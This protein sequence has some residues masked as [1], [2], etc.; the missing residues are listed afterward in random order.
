MGQVM[1]RTCGVDSGASCSPSW[2]DPAPT[3]AV[4]ALSPAV[5]GVTR[6]PAAAGAAPTRGLSGSAASLR[7]NLAPSVEV[8]GKGH[9]RAPTQLLEPGL[10][11]T[12]LPGQTSADRRSR[13]MGRMWGELRLAAEPAASYQADDSQVNESAGSGACASDATGTAAEGI[14]AAQIDAA[15][16]DL[17]AVLDRLGAASLGGLDAKHL[18]VL[19]ERIQ[20]ELGR[21]TALRASVTSRW[22][23]QARAAAGRGREQQVER[24]T[25][26]LLRDRLNLPPGEAKRTV[27]AGQQADAPGPVGDGFRDGRL[28]EAHLA[29]IADVGRGLTPDVRKRLEAELSAAAQELDPVALGRLAR[30]RLI[31]LEPENERRTEQRRHMRRRLSMTTTEDGGVRVSGQLYG[32]QAEKAMSAFHAFHSLDAPEQRRSPEH[33]GADAFEALCDVALRSGEAP[34]QHGQRPHVTVLVPW[35]SLVEQTGVA[36]LGFTGPISFEELRPLL[37]DAVVGRVVLDAD[38][39][40]IEVSRQ[41]RTVP[42]GLWRALVARDGGCTW[43]GCDVPPGWCQ[44]A[45]GDVPYRLEGRLELE[46]SALLCSRHHRNFDAGGWRMVID[47]ANV[48]YHPTTNEEAVGGEAAPNGALFGGP[49]GPP[50]GPPLS[51]DGASPAR[52]GLPSPRDARSSPRD[53]PSPPPK[54]PSSSWGGSTSPPRDGSSPPSSRTKAAAQ[55]GFDDA[56]G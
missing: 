18:E 47:G 22:Q 49:G 17:T 43:R 34:T 13:P 31:E 39:V 16:D 52:D 35:Q 21:L 33:R 42:A 24:E 30:R 4:A 28:S 2:L 8:Q 1:N 9:S 15:L 11:S 51:W 14:D 37:S 7:S 56:D 29:V 20:C 27:K 12:G 26:Q 40:P 45:H 10:M 46:N 55:L 32:V 3:V 38:G 50:H 53:G 6:S 5:S 19:L 48:S 41:V 44:A 25:R 36:E 54:G 23:E